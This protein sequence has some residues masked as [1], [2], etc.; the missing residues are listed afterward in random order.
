MCCDA[1][2]RLLDWLQ[3][4]TQARGGSLRHVGRACT[5]RMDRQ[6]CPTPAHF[7]LLCVCRSPGIIGGL[8]DA[9]LNHYYST[10]VIAQGLRVRTRKGLPQTPAAVVPQALAM[11]A[12][13]RAPTFPD[14]HSNCLL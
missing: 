14:S 3:D 10:G 12:T 1:C 6:L 7:A 11:P 4:S 2:L 13:L 8:I 9:F 5:I